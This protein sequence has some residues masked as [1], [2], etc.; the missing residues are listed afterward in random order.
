MTPLQSDGTVGYGCVSSTII[1][2]VAHGQRIL[3]TSSGTETSG[4]LSFVLT[5]NY[6]VFYFKYSYFIFFC[7]PFHITDMQFFRGASSLMVLVTVA[8]VCAFK[9]EATSSD[10]QTNNPAPF[11]GH[12]NPQTFTISGISAGACMSIQFEY[13]Y[14]SLVQAAGIVAGAPYMCSGGSLSG[15]LLCLDSPSLENVETLLAEA[16]ALASA[17]GIDP[18][19]NLA[20]HT[21]YLFSGA[22]DTVVPQQNMENV[23]SMYE[24]LN[25]TKV[26]SFFNY[27][28]QHSW[29]TSK[30]GDA[31][32]Y[33]GKPYINNCNID[34]G[35][36]FLH[37]AFT[38]MGLQWNNQ[39]GALNKSNLFTVDQTKQGANPTLNSLAANAYV[40]V[41]TACQ[42]PT[43]RCHLHM[44]LHGCTQSYTSIGTQYV[45]ETQLNE[46][47]EVNNII[48]LYPQATADLLLDN[49]EGCFDWW[50]YA[51]SNF[52]QKGGVQISVLRNLIKL[53][54]GF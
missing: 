28:A 39:P 48:V 38:N 16:A 35:G 6:S 36:K 37:A 10:S 15:A 52:A 24:A 14:S 20:Q 47:A 34:F 29:V 19:Q 12:C 54:G 42:S 23:R 25:V 1:D 13:A 50:G 3:T 18:L 9:I 4:F 17:G 46:W 22:I 27:S 32:S 43:A 31:C 45:L 30:Y 11:F 2:I 44:N 40:Y 8:I 49:P 33:L 21:V 5:Q 41:P 53:V 26:T 7:S 51:G